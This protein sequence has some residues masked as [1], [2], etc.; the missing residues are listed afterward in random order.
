MTACLLNP[1][2]S[3]QSTIE[4]RREQFLERRDSILKNLQFEFQELS[5]QCFEAG[6]TDAAQDV[7]ALSLELTQPTQKSKPPRGVQLPINPRLPPDQKS[8]RERVMKIRTDAAQDLYFTARSCLRAN[9]PTLAYSLI[10][11]VIRINPDHKHAR[12][13]MGQQLFVDPTQQGDPLYAGDWVSPFEAK[14]K[15]G[16]NPRVFDPRF[17]WIPMAHVARYEEGQRPWQR[18]KWISAEKEAELRRDFRN[19]WEIPSEN[20]LIRTNVGLEE[21]VQL[22]IKLEI[23]NDWLQNNFAAFFDTPKALQ[24]RFENA[25]VRR[26]GESDR[27]PMEVHFYATRDE[28]QKKM[29]GKVPPHIETNGLYWEPEHTCYFFLNPEA[30]DSST[31]FHEATHQILDIHTSDARRIAATVRARMN[32]TRMVPWVLCERSNFWMIEGLACYFESFRIQD[33]VASV[34]SPDYVR[35]VAAQHRLLVDNFYIPLEMFCSL[36]K[37]D[38]QRHPNI[39]QLYSQ[40]SGV[41]HFLLHY[42]NGRYQDD[43]VEL[44]SAA[45]RP[46]PRRMR[47]E[48]SLEKITGVSFTTLD[49][50]YREHMGNIAIAIQTLA[51][52]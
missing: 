44:L 12:A 49:Q 37:D 33:G 47:E 31:L 36:G 10:E 5:Q 4:R 51:G 43:F 18:T 39:A 48:P 2:A 11:D 38:F 15:S 35:F 8:W 7:T 29:R 32:R 14:M 30:E 16:S 17:G 28:Y 22:S 42:D 46:D 9:L 3:G 24:E 19:A 27:K 13:V 23:F 34:G 41:A 50:Q 6:L 20:F 25:Q 52:P 45:Y 26:R 40:A 21:G 1:H